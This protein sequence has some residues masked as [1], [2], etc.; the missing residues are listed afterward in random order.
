MLRHLEKLADGV[1][2]EGPELAAGQAHRMS[3]DRHVSYRL[4]KVID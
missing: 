1:F 3:L 4:A 2:V